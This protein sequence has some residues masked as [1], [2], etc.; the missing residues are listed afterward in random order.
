M[1][2]LEKIVDACYYLLK[3]YPEAKE[4]QDYLNSRIN[5]E[6][7]D[8]FKFGY[9]P[10]MTNIEALSSIVGIELLKESSIIYSKEIEDSLYPRTINICTFEDYPIIIPFRDCYGVV[11][12]LVGRTL[13]SEEDRK[14]KKI[15]KYKNNLGFTKTSHVFGLYENKKS[16]LEKDCVFLVEGQ[17]DVIKAHE[18]GFT[19]IL[20]IGSANLSLNQ[21]SLITRYTNNIFLLLDNDDA[22]RKGRKKIVNKFGKYANIQ[23]FYIPDTYKD[24]DDYLKVVSY[25]N[26]EFTIVN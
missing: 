9:F 5:K 8:K 26:M 2:N 17:L 23:N 19:N 11:A 1:N 15:D 4:C 14:E 3:E 24:I 18:Q 25:E 16:I 6:C 12:G 13:L 21:F 22:G 20:G 10:N 7:Q